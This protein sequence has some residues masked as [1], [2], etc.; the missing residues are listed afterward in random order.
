M[1]SSKKKYNLLKKEKSPY[2]LQHAA[3]LVNW[4][5]WSQEAFDIAKKE[6]KPVFLS[7][8]YSTCHWCH[9]MAHESFEDEEV[10]E[11]LNNN[12]VCIKV[13][14]EERPDIDKIYMNVCQMITGS[15]GWPLTIIMTPDKEPFFAATYIPK[16]SRYGIKGLL[17]L[18]SEIKKLWDTKSDSLKKSASE[19]TKAL[20]KIKKH[21][22]QR[23]LTEKTIET[24]F[25]QLFNSFD[26]LNG[27]FGNQ[28]K[29]PT[30]HNLLFLL[31]YWKRTGNKYSLK[32]VEKT[33]EQMRQGG[34][35]D[36][37][38]F[39][40]HRYS[41]DRKWIL[42][43]FEKMLYDQALMIIAYT[44][45]Y[46]ATKKQIFKKTA[47]E[48]I[49]YVLRDMTDKEGGFYSAEDADSEGKE[50]KF[51][52]WYY[53]ELKNILSS[54][55]FKIVEKLF[56]IKSNGNFSD[57]DGSLD[58]KNIMYQS[59]SIDEYSKFF[60]LER[61][62]L[63]NELEKIRVKLFDKRKERIHPEKDEKILTDWNG[64][65]IA[66][67]S[68]ASYVFNEISYNEYAEKAVNFIS[69]NMIK[70]NGEL[71]HRYK[72][73]ESRIQGYADD[74]AFLIFGLIELYQATFNSKYL[75]KSLELNKFLLN[76]FWDKSDSGLFFTS[77]NGEKLITQT[78]EIYDGAIPSANSLTVYNLIRLA[79]ITGNT[80]F[81]EKAKQIG[82]IFYD[83][84]NSYPTGHTQLMIGLDF[85]IGPS[86]EIVI[87]GDKN[88]ADVKKIINELNKIYLPNIVVI[89]KEPNSK[90]SEIDNISPFIKNY[91]QIENKATIYVC[92]N[93]HCKLPTTC[94]EKMKK[95]FE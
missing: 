23:E 68:K 8:G 2:L 62:K 67:L 37:I 79:R 69:K 22:I 81:E 39:G 51:Y 63:T 7:I 54:E 40:F 24:T 35:Y 83:Q 95:H 49:E 88:K 91:S 84:I 29:F 30:P 72:D 86:F 12:F 3:N 26:E 32:M 31:R 77:D 90:D 27:G 66:A 33:L 73:G 13:D 53:E 93:Q 42:P 45:A 46:Q 19:I 16:H 80:D 36:H 60:S 17:V 87:I 28:P 38:G 5:P 48:I 34:I 6:N 76:H 58:K 74:Y 92:R 47:Q 4:Y 25:E 94:I 10:A 11:Q 41:T 21:P 89:L 18:I 20:Q 59:M 15:G 55:E 82:I 61:E 50:G 70:K 52:T 9:V 78:K 64:L 57:V 44:E 71:L 75:K 85:A 43:H 56:S 65:M 14:R 1:S